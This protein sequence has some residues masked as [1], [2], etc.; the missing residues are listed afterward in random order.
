MIFQLN[1]S[2][3]RN[4]SSA[5][6]NIVTNGLKTFG[7]SFLIFNLLSMWITGKRETKQKEL[8][9]ASLDLI[10]QIF[11]STRHIKAL[12]FYAVK[13]NNFEALCDCLGSVR[14]DYFKVGVRD[15]VRNTD[16]E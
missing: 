1:L 6:S 7:N 12:S 10:R 8:N 15:D 9:E 2:S 5:L 11:K 14:I 3:N 16:V 4:D 13:E